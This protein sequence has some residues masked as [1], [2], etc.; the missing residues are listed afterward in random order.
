MAMLQTLTTSV[1]LV[2]AKASM[3]TLLT[4]DGR[5]MSTWNMEE[6]ASI[7]DDGPVKLNSGAGNACKD[8]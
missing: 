3:T 5:C 6:A 2:G 7:T 8:M 4:G 1:K